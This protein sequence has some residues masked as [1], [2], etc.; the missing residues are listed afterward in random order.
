MQ[1]SQFAGEC[2]ALKYSRILF[3]FMYINVKKMSTG[4][5]LKYEKIKPLYKGITKDL[6]LD[7]QSPT[8]YSQH[9]CHQQKNYTWTVGMCSNRCPSALAYTGSSPKH[10]CV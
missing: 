9:P 2:W 6:L 7:C 4:E 5:I 8:I 1:K 10:S 3:Y